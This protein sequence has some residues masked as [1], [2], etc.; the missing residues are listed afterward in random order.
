MGSAHVVHERT[1][2]KWPGDGHFNDRTFKWGR[3]FGKSGQRDFSR[4]S[5]FAQNRSEARLQY[6]V[7]LI[8]RNKAHGPTECTL[9]S[10]AIFLLQC[11]L[12]IFAAFRERHWS[13]KIEIV[14]EKS[15]VVVCQLVV[16]DNRRDARHAEIGLPSAEAR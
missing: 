12:V 9:V 3:R 14:I 1:F 6:S 13:I 7:E 11:G 15:V 10:A 4:R 16:F 2:S 5:V 8:I